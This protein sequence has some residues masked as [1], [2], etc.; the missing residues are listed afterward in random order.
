VAGNVTLAAIEVG[1][2]AVFASHVMTSPE[3]NEKT[4]SEVLRAEESG[5]IRT[6]V[7]R[8]PQ[9]YGPGV[10]NPL[11]KPIYDAALQGKK[12]HWI[13]DLEVQRSFLD[14]EDAARAMVMLGGSPA[15]QGKAWSVSAPTPLTGREFIELAF[16]AAGNEPKVG[17]WGRGIVLTG[18]LLASGSREILGMPYDY[19]SPFV[20]DGS[21]FAEAFPSFSYTSPEKS[22]GAALARYKEREKV[23][24]IRGR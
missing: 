24:E 19:Y 8:F 10:M 22:M 12:A 7:A 15:A 2:A 14:V 6:T 20:L 13:G 16:K 17:K 9:L 11:F 5:L 23:A 21:G 4:E 18:S 1:A 3:D